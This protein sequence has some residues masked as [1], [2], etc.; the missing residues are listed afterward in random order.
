VTKGRRL[1]VLLG[2]LLP[3]LLPPGQAMLPHAPSL[4]RIKV[5]L[6]GDSTVATQGGWGPGFCSHLVPEAECLDLAANGRST[7]SFRDEGRWSQAL[8]RHGQ[9]YFLQFGHND[10]KDRPALH[11]DPES[12]FKTNL[13]RYLQ[14]VRHIGGEA[15]LVTSLTRRNFQNGQLLVDPLREYAAAT[16]E[17]AAEE[18]VPLLDLYQLSRQVI[19]PMT[20]EQADR[21]NMVHHEDAT[22]EGATATTPDRTH[23][24]ALG[25]QTFGDMVAQAAYRNVPALRP[26]LQV[27]PPHGPQ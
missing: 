20:Q 19:E 22:A 25:Q 17:V 9:F 2:S 24:N 16:R 15:V 27:R 26:Y 8:A 18:H 5:V 4:K 7:K 14:D 1:I 21:F 10:Q 6:V 23:L 12:T 11:T 3:W 13:K